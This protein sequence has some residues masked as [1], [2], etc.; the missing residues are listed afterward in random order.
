MSIQNR[1]YLNNING[2]SSNND[3]EDVVPVSE[4]PGP[5]RPLLR[6]AQRQLK[7]INLQGPAA[8]LLAAAVAALISF[9][10]A[11]AK[12]AIIL[13]ISVATVWSLLVV[14]KDN[15]E[16]D[17]PPKSPTVVPKPDTMRP[18]PPIPKP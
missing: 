13:G 10:V 2:I 1:I 11:P 14:H 15:R 18:G 16:F 9:G 5:L 12:I 6:D 7:Q 17:R 4:G 8:L 3:D